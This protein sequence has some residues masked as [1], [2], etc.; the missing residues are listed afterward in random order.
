M[1]LIVPRGN[2]FLPRK[3]FYYYMRKINTNVRD[4]A[5]DTYY[6]LII[7]L[8]LAL[9]LAGELSTLT[10][11]FNSPTII[12]ITLFTLLQSNSGFSLTA[13][14]VRLIWYSLPLVEYNYT[15]R[16]IY[17]KMPLRTCG[18][19]SHSQMLDPQ[20]VFLYLFG[21]HFQVTPDSKK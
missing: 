9:L 3:I 21:T 18:Q 12:P 2:L 8:I 16:S 13:D 11:S 4:V 5:Q 19:N 14:F 15:I 17:D 6:F 7:F 1:I 10:R 20:F